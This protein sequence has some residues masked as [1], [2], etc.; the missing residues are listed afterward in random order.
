MN[1]VIDGPFVRRAALTDLR[2]NLAETRQAVRNAVMS[3]DDAQ[4]AKQ[5]ESYESFF[6]TVIERIDACRASG[7]SVPSPTSMP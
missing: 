1:A 6:A 2:S 7:T 5:R 4:I 3:R